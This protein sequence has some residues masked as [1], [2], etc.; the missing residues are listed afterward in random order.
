MLLKNQID[1]MGH[2]R[3]ASL[4]SGVFIVVSLISLAFNWL[5]LGLDFSSGIAVRLTYSD[6]VNLDEVH[7]SLSENGYTE[8]LV[9]SYGSD[10]DVRI[11]LPVSQDTQASEQ[12][13]QAIM[14][15]EQ[16]ADQLRQTTESVITLAGSDFVS[17]KAGQD[18]AERSGLGILVALG[19]IMIYISMRFQFK[20]AV[21]AVVALLHDV[22]ITLGIFSVFRLQFDLTVLAALL[23]VIGYSLNDTIIVADRVRENLRRERRGTMVELV[24]RS[25]N[26][27]LSR[28]LITSGTT[29][30]VVLSLLLVGSESVRGFCIAMTVGIVAGTYSTIYIA[31]ALL[32]LMNVQREDVALALSEDLGTV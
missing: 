11:V 27:T 26:Q 17:A 19:V 3:T 25:L 2:R 21:G 14:V 18:L 20:F 4:V 16:L 6:Y 32:L 31:S 22:I 28:T 10:R 30:M 5:Q 8:A 13:S 23:A 12:A 7:A 29:L 15:G 24:N 9:V 1:F